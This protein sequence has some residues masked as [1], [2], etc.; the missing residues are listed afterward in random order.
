ARHSLRSSLYHL[1]QAL[2]ARGAERTLLVQGDLVSLQHATTTC[3]VGHFRR[4][5][6]ATADEYIWAEAV[7]L[8]HGPLLEGFTL[9]DAP[10]FEEWVRFTGGELRQAYLAALDRLAGSAASR[11]SWSEVVRY[12]QRSVQVD[13]LAE[14]TQQRLIEAYLH[15]GAI[16]A[17]L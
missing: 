9:S 6:A 14:E 5:V 3:D 17:A 11:R 2:Q 7:S 16:G 10:E 13:P 8:Y 12:L 4:L 15:L 1:R